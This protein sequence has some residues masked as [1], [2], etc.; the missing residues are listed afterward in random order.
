MLESMIQLILALVVLGVALW[1]IGPYLADPIPK[2]ITVIVILWAL[3]V[4]LQLAGV[5]LGFR[6]PQL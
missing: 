1:L 3:A 6:V 4:V 2:V 5:T